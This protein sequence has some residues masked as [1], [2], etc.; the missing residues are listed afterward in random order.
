MQMMKWDGKSFICNG[1][2]WAECVVLFN[3]IK[4]GKMATTHSVLIKNTKSKK[5]YVI[6]CVSS[7]WELSA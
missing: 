2:P 1:W 7:Q 6:I 4:E 3:A 5:T